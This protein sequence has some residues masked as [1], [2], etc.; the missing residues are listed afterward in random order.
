MIP[1]LYAKNET[2]FTSNGLGRLAECVSCTV[3]EERN[4]IYE[5]EFQY[6]ITGKLYGEII[7]NG[8]IIA[9][10]HDDRHDVQPF[11]I[12]AHSAP[13]D[14]IVTFHAHHISYRQSRIIATPYTA[15]SCADALSK[16]GTNSHPANPFTYWT[17]KDVSSPFEIK[18]PRSVNDLLRGTEGSILDVYGKGEYQFD[19]FTVRLYV[20]RGVDSGVTIRYGKN[21]TDITKDYDE[22]ACFSAIAPY[23]ASEEETVMLPEVY[24]G[25]PGM[26][27]APVPMD[28]SGE[29]PEKPTEAQLRDRANAYLAANTPWLPAENVAV[30]FVQLWQTKEYENVAALQRLSLCDTVSVFYPALGVIQNGKKVIKVVYNVLLERYDEMELGQLQTS[31]ADN[32]ATQLNRQLEQKASVSFLRAAIE[33]AT[34]QI[35]GALGGYIVFTLNA[36][37]WPTEMLIMD[38]PDVMTAVNVWRWNSGGLGHS[39]NGYNGP[40][41]DVALTQDGQINATMITTGELNAARVVTGIL[42]DKEGKNSWNLDTGELIATEMQLTNSVIKLGNDNQGYG[43]VQKNGTETN[44]LIYPH[45]PGEDLKPSPGVIRTTKVKMQVGGEVAVH[46]QS[47]YAPAYIDTYFYR[48]KVDDYGFHFQHRTASDTWED[49]YVLKYGQIPS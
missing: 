30:N 37:G 9:C 35:T 8:G 33:H 45:S 16:I 6:P 5:C 7:E 25:E 32:I 10:W 29:F 20:N 27:A 3:T 47:D 28:F 18:V 11:D 14:G 13:I 41:D 17:E 4:G 23:W 46:L 24:V 42:T 48:L 39:H 22:S 34:E 19:K 36:A 2:A 31:L 38:T 44:T 15:T 49:L 40:F 12:Y 43:Y 1:I 26:D 21:L